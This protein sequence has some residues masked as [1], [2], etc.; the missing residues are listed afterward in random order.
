ME[1]ETN[2]HFEGESG[3]SSIDG[4]S[5]TYAGD[6]T[7]TIDISGT[8]RIPGYMADCNWEPSGWAEGVFTGQ[9]SCGGAISMN[10]EGFW[11]FYDVQE[12][13]FSGYGTFVGTGVATK[14][15]GVPTPQS[16]TVDG[17]EGAT[18]VPL[19]TIRSGEGHQHIAEDLHTGPSVREDSTTTTWGVIKSNF[20]DD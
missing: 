20:A 6:F 16:I 3:P 10:L 8:W 15:T 1:G 7:G 9:T 4:R 19:T 14:S 13:T 17:P 11:G 2:T 12:C 18:I 5:A